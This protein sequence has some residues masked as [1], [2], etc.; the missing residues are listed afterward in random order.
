MFDNKHDANHDQTHEQQK[1]RLIAHHAID[2]VA[3]NGT[4]AKHK[5]SSGEPFRIQN[6]VSTNP[7]P[8]SMAGPAGLY[9]SVLK[10]EH[11][12]DFRTLV[13]GPAEEL[14]EI[15]HV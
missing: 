9:F 7:G 6:I 11:K 2:D 15:F 12:G 5:G 8:R 13:G 1:L 14:R 10:T 3:I 4:T